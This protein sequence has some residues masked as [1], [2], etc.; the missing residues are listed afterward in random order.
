MNSGEKRNLTSVISIILVSN[1]SSTIMVRTI[2]EKQ[3]EE[4]TKESEAGE[5]EIYSF[6]LAKDISKVSTEDLTE[7]STNAKV[8]STIPTAK[9]NIP[10]EWRQNASYA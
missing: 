6:K 1:V 10:R 9:E 8:E 4:V 3:I 2:L 7:E 5:D